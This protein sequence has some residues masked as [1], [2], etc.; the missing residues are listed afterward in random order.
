MGTWIQGQIQSTLFHTFGVPK[1]KIEEII[2]HDS[3]FF[4]QPFVFQV[5]GRSWLAG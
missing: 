4:Y 2:I 1:K 3:K 5:S